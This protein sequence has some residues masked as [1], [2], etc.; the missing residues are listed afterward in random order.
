MIMQ[1]NHLPRK[2]W[3]ER[4][5]FSKLLPTVFSPIPFVISYNVSA[6]ISHSWLFITLSP[7]SH[8]ALR[9]VIF[10]FFPVCFSRL[11]EI[12]TRKCWSHP[13]IL[14]I[15]LRDPD[16]LSWSSCFL[17]QMTSPTE[18]SHTPPPPH[19]QVFW[20]GFFSAVSPSTL[21]YVPPIRHTTCI[22]IELMICASLWSITRLLLHSA[23]PGD[24]PD[25]NWT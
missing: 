22:K 9:E 1:L 18:I 3:C 6:Y 21:L 4:I 2:N 8:L 23:I 12:H 14:S 25:S 16:L 15:S 13:H 10:N 24:A 17:H 20:V 11:S 19:W 7:F 5:H